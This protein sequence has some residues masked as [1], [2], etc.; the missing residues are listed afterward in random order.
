MRRLAD[1][2]GVGTMTIYSYFRSKEELL[3]AVVDAAATQVD[4]DG[5]EGPWKARLRWL[6]LT[7]HQGLKEHPAAVE[8]RLRRP[9]LSPGALQFTE[10]GLCILRDAGF[11]KREAARAYRI[12]FI[13]TFGYS[14]FGPSEQS[15]ADRELNRRA[16]SALPVDRYPVLADLVDEASD[17]MAD[18]TLFELGLDRLLDGFEASL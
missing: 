8:L 3:D 4:F 6:M 9:L 18:Q 2:L 10:T 13:Y 11:S 14:A 16:M 15:E 5:G 12:L 1:E 7:L 17:A